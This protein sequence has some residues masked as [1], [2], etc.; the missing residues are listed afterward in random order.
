MS[1]LP[2]QKILIVADKANSRYYYQA[3][4]C[5]DGHTVYTPKVSYPSIRPYLL[6][7]KKENITTIILSSAEVLGK[8]I[9][10][11]LGKESDDNYSLQKW[12]GAILDY[13][14]LKILVVRPLKQLVTQDYAKFLLKSYFRKL[15][16]QSMYTPPPMDWSVVNTEHEREQAYQLMLTS[17][18]TS[19]DIETTKV[20]VDMDKWASMKS[21]GIPVNGLAAW[22]KQTGGKDP[23]LSIPIIDMIGYTILLQGKDGSLYSKTIVLNI[24]SMNDIQ[25][26]RKYN[27]TKCIKI[28]QNG[29]YEASHLI[30]YNAPLR[31]WTEIGR[32]HV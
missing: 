2:L 10:E 30:R 31:N 16:L 23:L 22:M 7:C 5:L 21:Q 28:T 15:L 11:K 3:R 17:E 18:Y 14:G 25:W 29:G 26:M 6:Q 9:T 32:A 12:A 27:A 1:H 13:E 8:L 19:V 20:P 24:R 4:Q